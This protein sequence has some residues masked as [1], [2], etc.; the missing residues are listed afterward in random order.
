MLCL[1]VD[2][3]R[4]MEEHKM[5]VKGWV[6]REP[7]VCALERRDYAIFSTLWN[8]GHFDIWISRAGY[9]LF[10]PFRSHIGSL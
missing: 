3:M 9:I 5:R 7:R 6:A 1:L 8:P 2:A 4:E 10:G